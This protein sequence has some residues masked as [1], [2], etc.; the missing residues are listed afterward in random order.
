MTIWIV[1]IEDR[2]IDVD[3]RPFSHLP[4]AV[5]AAGEWASDQRD[6]AEQEITDSMAADGWVFFLEYGTEGDCV[7]VVERELDGP[8]TS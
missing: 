3:A 2:H 5:A 1:I 8:L 4:L 6:V 7:R